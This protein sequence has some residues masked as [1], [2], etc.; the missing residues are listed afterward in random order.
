MEKVGCG[1][2]AAAIITPNTIQLKIKVKS[3]EVRFFSF[4]REEEMLLRGTQL[5]HKKQNAEIELEM[6]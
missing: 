4:K 2:P 3:M 5:F 1:S 6:N